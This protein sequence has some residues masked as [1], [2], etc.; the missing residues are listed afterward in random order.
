MRRENFRALLRHTGILLQRQG[1]R[2]LFNAGVGHTPT[3]FYRGLAADLTEARD[4][5]DS[6]IAALEEA[7]G[8]EAPS[9]GRLTEQITR[10]DAF[11]RSVLHERGESMSPPVEP[12]PPAAL[13]GGA[14]PSDE[15]NPAAA[16]LASPSLSAAGPI[17]NREDAYRRLAEIAEYLGRI[18]PHSPTPYLIRRAVAWGNMT[19]AELLDELTMGERDIAVVYQ[20]LGIHD[21][22]GRG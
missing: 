3:E 17:R 1:T 5:A 21:R 9:L 6:L 16:D 10:L 11:A 20:L 8:T 12:P 13:A 15:A 7:C 22:S 18:E 4:A 14:T 2:T 19:L